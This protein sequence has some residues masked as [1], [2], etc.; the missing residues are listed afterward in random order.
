MFCDI[1]PVIQSRVLSDPEYLNGDQKQ[2][3]RLVALRAAEKNWRSEYVRCL[4]GFNYDLNAF[5]L[6][7]VAPKSLM[8]QIWGIK[9]PD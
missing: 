4:N 2:Q 3:A 9:L 1:Q 6:I 8:R 5:A 7:P